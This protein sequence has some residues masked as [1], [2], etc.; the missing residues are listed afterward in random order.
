MNAAG[1]VL[2]ANAPL[3]WTCALATIAAAGEPLLAADGGAN[4]LA[5]I[6]LKPHTVIGD[7]DSMTPG[8]RAWIGEERLVHRPDQDR[9]D[10][11]K[12]LTFVFD[13][14]TLERLTVLAALG[15]RHDHAA[16]NLGL[17]ARL[18]LGLRLV[19]RGENFVSFAVTGRQELE[20]SPG[21]TW[22]FWSYDP[23]VRVTLDGVRWPVR[24]AD[25]SV[26]TRPSISN[27]AE[28]RS[29]ILVAERGPVVVTRFF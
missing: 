22:S 16:G 25:L 27:V 6:G 15:G 24:Q 20:A 17:L 29:I 10:L 28:G 26:A 11:E 1:P 23:R 12:A 13:E 4:H 21:E 14:L 3:H 9:T 8:T 19:F 7:F 2:V 18:C 5:R